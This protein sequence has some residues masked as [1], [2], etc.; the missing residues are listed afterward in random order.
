MHCLLYWLFRRVA[1]NDDNDHDDWEVEK[2]LEEEEEEGE[3]EVDDDDEISKNKEQDGKQFMIATTERA[4]RKIVNSKQ[5]II[6]LVKTILHF[7]I[8]LQ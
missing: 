5:T 8:V 7:F 6:P 1:D 2:W 4:T 3:E